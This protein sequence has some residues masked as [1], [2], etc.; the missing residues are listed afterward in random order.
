MGDQITTG[1]YGIVARAGASWGVIEPT[2]DNII[3][4]DI[5]FYDSYCGVR[6]ENTIDLLVQRT[7]Y[8]TSYV[9]A[10]W[11]GAYA[12]YLSGTAS[13]GSSNTTVRENVVNKASIWVTAVSNALIEGNAV[14]NA[15]YNGIWLGQ[16]FATGTGSDGVI[17]NN[18]IDGTLEGGIVVWNLPGEATGPIEILNNDVSN[19]GDTE[20]DPRAGIAIYNVDSTPLEIRGN[21]STSNYY[22]GLFLSSSNLTY[23]RVT[24]N[25]FNN[26]SV[27]GVRIENVTV[28]DVKFFGNTIY[29]NSKFGMRTSGTG[30]VDATLNSWGDASGP[31]HSSSWLLGALLITN[32]DGLGDAVTDYVLYSPWLGQ[33][34]VTGGGTISSEPGDYEL[35]PTAGGQASFGFTAKY[36][37]GANVPDGNTNFVFQ[38]GELHF[39]S[40]DYDWLIVA[41]DTA[42][43][44]GTGTIDGLGDNFKFMLWAGDG[45][46]DTFRILIWDG[47]EE[48]PLA[49]VYDNGPGDAITGGNII[50]H[51]DKGKK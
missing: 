4:Q 20:W 5:T 9:W 41:G 38:A 49:L 15:P 43:F 3:V 24:E 17:Q 2:L 48:D 18:T 21:V 34:L 19:T 1:G 45:D 36:K 11:D 51:K 50:I 22:H 16:Q 40:S 12:Y 47:T 14:T 13:P 10:R 29:G 46:P 26:N 28:G 6:G 35:D 23:A 7:N 30:I 33:G 39:H 27:D 31:Y 8:D 25:S 44:K 42:R 37:K 32:P